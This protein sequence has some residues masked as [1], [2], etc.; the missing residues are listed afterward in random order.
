[1]EEGTGRPYDT[2]VSPLEETGDA[3]GGDAILKAASGN[4]SRGKARKRR[5]VL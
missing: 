4:K 1:M 2:I 3:D 5:L